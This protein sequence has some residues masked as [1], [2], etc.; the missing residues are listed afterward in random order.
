VGDGSTYLL[1]NADAAGQ[2]RFTEETASMAP[3]EKLALLLKP[4]TNYALFDLLAETAAMRRTDAAGRLPV[5]LSG[6][7]IRLI[8]VVPAG[9]GPFLAFTDCQRR[10][11]GSR[12]DLP[13]RLYSH[14]G[15][16]RVVVGGLP[17]GTKL[18]VDGKPVDVEQGGDGKMSVVRVPRGEHSLS[19]R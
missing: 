4:D 2:A 6:K 19:V 5:F 9:Q 8:Q 17:T 1:L 10:D 13:A 7:N 16:G 15:N 12:R 14:R 11:A 18:L 3:A